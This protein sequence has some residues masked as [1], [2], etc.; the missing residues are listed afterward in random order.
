VRGT[1]FADGE[2]H[3]FVVSPAQAV[4]MLLLGEKKST[5]LDL[6]LASNIPRDELKRQLISMC[7]SKYQVFSKLQGSKREFLDADEYEFNPTFKSKL[8]RIKIPT[9][10]MTFPVENAG[11]YVFCSV[12]QFI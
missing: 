7:V 8:R 10:I 6:Q 1:G 9:V 12:L 2:Q 3:D 11:G 4:L 5:F